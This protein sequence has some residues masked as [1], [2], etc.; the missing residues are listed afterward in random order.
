MQLHP[1]SCRIESR[2]DTLFVRPVAG[3]ALL[4]M[5]VM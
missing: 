5:H 4:T 1:A 2:I 3:R